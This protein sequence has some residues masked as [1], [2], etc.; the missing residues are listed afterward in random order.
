MDVHQHSNP[1]SN[2]RRAL[3]RQQS[4]CSSV[5]WILWP[6]SHLWSVR[7]L[8]HPNI[9]IARIRHDLYPQTIPVRH[10]PILK[11]QLRL[12]IRPGL[13]LDVPW[14]R[15]SVAYRLNCPSG[16]APARTLQQIRRDVEVEA[17]G[18]ETP[19]TDLLFKEADQRI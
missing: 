3:Q 12:R 2:S 19:G 9:P 5:A 11:N 7:L 18:R 10:A 8:S 1:H 15:T 13:Y 16:A 6:K 14:S 17:T 4:L